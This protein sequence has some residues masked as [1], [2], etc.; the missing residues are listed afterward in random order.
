MHPDGINNINTTNGYKYL[1]LL[2]EIL[3]II[4]DIIKVNIIFK[5]IVIT[6]VS[7]DMLLAINGN[8]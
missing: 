8:I 6:I 3:Q 1:I 4:T 7:L 5:N 2:F